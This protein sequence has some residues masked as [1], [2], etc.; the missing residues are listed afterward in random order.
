MSLTSKQRSYL[1]GLANNLDPIIQ[2]GKGGITAN[3]LLQVDEAL[4]AREVVKGKVL[5]NYFGGV[6]ETA[7]ELATKT[8]AEVVQVIGS[9]FVLYRE[10]K[11]N[12]IKLP[13]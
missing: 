6:R 4:E 9:I 1:R 3:L 5:K 12:K 2:V 11:E 8:G 10:S 7:V 13:T